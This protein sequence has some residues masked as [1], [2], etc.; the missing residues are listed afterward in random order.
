MPL[1][2]FQ[3]LICLIHTRITPSIIKI[4]IPSLTTTTTI[5]TIIATTTTTTTAMTKRKEI[6][7][8]KE[9]VT[10]INSS[11]DKLTTLTFLT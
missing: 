8:I 4:I 6:V 5:T 3:I 1:K 2:S 10:R 7:I 9:V 11:L